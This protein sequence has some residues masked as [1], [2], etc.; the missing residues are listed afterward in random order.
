MMEQT[1]IIEPATEN[2]DIIDCGGE[3]EELQ[4]ASS[5]WSAVLKLHW[6]TDLR[7]PFRIKEV[8][9]FPAP[10][11]T[12]ADISRVVEDA[13]HSA[14]N[15]PVFVVEWGVLKGK[16]R[17][18]V[19]DAGDIAS[20]SKTVTEMLSS[21]SAAKR[22]VLLYAIL[23]ERSVVKGK[24]RRQGS[25]KQGVRKRLIM[26]PGTAD[27][28]QSES[29][30]WKDTSLDLQDSHVFSGDVDSDGGFSEDEETRRTSGRT[31]SWKL[32][33]PVLT[34]LQTREA[35]LMDTLDDLKDRHGGEYSHLQYRFWAQA[36]CNS[37]WSSFDSPPPGRMFTAGT[38]A[39]KTGDASPM[40]QA[41]TGAAQAFAMM[42]KGGPTETPLVAAPPPAQRPTTTAP[43]PA[44]LAPVL[45]HSPSRR[46]EMRAQCYKQLQSLAEMREKGILTEDMYEEERAA[47][48][49]DLRRLRS[50]RTGNVE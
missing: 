26:S 35:Q 10:P 40:A 12:K 17:M 11:F 47:I 30:P 25:G 9:G 19:S 7:S 18:E 33:A 20:L 48:L 6:Q 4:A 15:E 34:P 31:Q 5:E 38:R 27:V 32:P 8:H 49:E 1:V 13:I 22:K 28:S 39:K 3:L 50:P 42:I 2:A 16:Y 46:S 23:V 24:K 21:G 45:V 14:T 37:R 41:L 44:A 29:T 36:I 43:K